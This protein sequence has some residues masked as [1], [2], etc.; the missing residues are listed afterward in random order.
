MYFC[1]KI[2]EMLV[3]FTVKNFRSFKHER[4]FSMEAS[5]IKEHKES[6]KIVNKHKVLPLAVI[7]GANSSGK[8]N[9]IKALGCMTQIVMNSVRL[10]DSDT[11][12][13]D[14]FALDEVSEQKPTFFE[15]QFIKDNSLF[16]YGFE[17]TPKEIISEWLYEKRFGEKEY[18]L[19]LRS[20]GFISMSNTRFKE[21]V[22]K[23][24]L[25]NANRLFVS[26]VAQLKGAVSKQVMDWFASCNV[27]S[28]LDSEAFEG[29]TLG[30][31]AEK[32]K[33]V[34]QAL[35]FFKKL[36]LGFNSFVVKRSTF[37]NDVVEKAP[38]DIKEKIREG[39][40]V[41]TFTIHNVYNE[42]GDVVKEKLFDELDMESEGTK[43]VI[44]M[45]GPIFDTLNEGRVLV[46]DELDAK[47]HPLLTRNIV[48]L[49]MNP[50][51]NKNN[52]QLVF[53]THDTNLLNLKLL[54]R[55]QIWFAEKDKCDS[56]DI[57]SLVEFKD[58]NGDKV[59]NDRNIEKDYIAGR[60]G[61]IPFIGRID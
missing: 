35:A 61:A 59:R 2:R 38:N 57:Y 10:N 56:T 20:R 39:K 8:S 6:I 40:I 13:Y 17:Y 60:Y 41:D 42:N 48:L 33:G 23:T 7:Y 49:F 4:T 36:Q 52:A 43:K 51:I 22:G 26:L 28:G 31:F 19:F 58:D 5:S 21:G 25:T 11:I 16:R 9:L 55:D 53:A 34:D 1:Q 47:L 24:D 44:E 37:A 18:N 12:P 50:E 29:F 45:S 15:I 30:M 27:L 32:N 54:R 46:V 3:N 14:P